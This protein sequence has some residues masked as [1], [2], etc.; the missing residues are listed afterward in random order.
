M[1][2]CEA[3]KHWKDVKITETHPRAL[4]KA[5]HL[6][7]EPW[8]TIA[9]KFDLDGPEPQTRDQLDALLS[10]AVARNGYKHV[11]TVN[12]TDL[13]RSEGEMDPQHTFFGKVDYY[14]FERIT[15]NAG[16]DDTQA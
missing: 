5:M 9:E 4:R 15:P 2:A 12:L 10:A 8:S 6:N 13:S 7:E 16:A 14:W 11:W 3:R 1:L